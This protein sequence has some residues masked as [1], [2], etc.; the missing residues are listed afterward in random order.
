[1]KLGAIIAVL[2]IIVVERCSATQ[3]HY[4]KL[5]DLRDGELQSTGCECNS[6]SCGCCADLVVEKVELNTTACMNLSYLP[7]QFGISF[8]IS[9][10]GE[11]VFNETI[12]ARN[13][14]PICFGIPYLEKYFSLCL[15]FYNMEFS[16]SKLSGCARLDARLYEV[17]VESIEL[18]CFKIPPGNQVTV[19]N[20]NK[21]RKEEFQVFQQ[22]FDNYIH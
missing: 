1:M 8:T 15:Q 4:N 13:P 14:P 19:T 6:T 20:K 16:T 10:G 17:V 9:L 5:R 2:C 11:V 12:S 3:H 21:P 7:D 22:G 18:G